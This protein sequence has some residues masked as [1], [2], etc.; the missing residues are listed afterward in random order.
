MANHSFE[1]KTPQDF[2][3]ALLEQ[4]EE[5]KANPLSSRHA[6]ICAI[7]CYH[8]KEW[9]VKSDLN[10]SKDELNNRIERTG[11]RARFK[12]FRELCN[13]SKHAT[14]KEENEKTVNETFKHNGAFSN[15]FSNGFD[16]SG[17]QIK[18]KDKSIYYFV[19]ELE[20]AVNFWTELFQELNNKSSEPI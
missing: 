20:K 10:C 1:I 16:V 11:N 18:M 3:Q 5:F 7:L 19:V 4:Y 12:L 2:F 6:I 17:L 14:L 13:G 8:L 15:G 9:V